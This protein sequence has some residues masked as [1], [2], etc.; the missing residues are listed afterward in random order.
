M[1]TAVTSLRY[2]IF[3]QIRF[4]QSF[5]DRQNPFYCYQNKLENNQM[6]S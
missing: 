5:P 1:N 4:A 6:K 3:N 2:N